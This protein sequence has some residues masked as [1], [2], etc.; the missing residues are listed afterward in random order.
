MFYFI[1]INTIYTYDVLQ[2][3]RHD[4]FRLVYLSFIFNNCSL[5]VLAKMLVLPS[6]AESNILAAVAS[7]G[8]IIVA[9]VK[10]LR[11]TRWNRRSG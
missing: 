1:K 10:A 7:A 9:S 6:V 4:I 2:T 8:G 3:K 5:T 11:V